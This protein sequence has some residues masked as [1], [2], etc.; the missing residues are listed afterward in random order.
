MITD[1][2]LKVEKIIVLNCWNL[3]MRLNFNEDKVLLIIFL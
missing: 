2:S 3:Q 1:N